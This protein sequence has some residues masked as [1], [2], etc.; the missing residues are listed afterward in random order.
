MSYG[1]LRKVLSKEYNFHCTILLESP[2][3]ETS[4]SGK[5]LQFVLLALTPEQ[6]LI[7][8]ETAP[9]VSKLNERD[10]N[11]NNINLQYLYP[12]ELVHIKVFKRSHRQTLKVCIESGKTRYFELAAMKKR[13]IF[14]KL[15]CNHISGLPISSKIQANVKGKSTKDHQTDCIIIEGKKKKNFRWRDKYLYL[16]S[17]RE[18]EDKVRPI[19][20]PGL[21]P[22]ED[23]KLLYLKPKYFGSW[24]QSEHW[25][26]CGSSGSTIFDF[27]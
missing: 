4:R 15:W 24:D 22:T 20:V 9:M 13:K 10:A 8:I 2:F 12:L 17:K 16:G 11:N 19:P 7:A 6:V 21:G 27:F 5:Y 3:I 18:T 1:K 23:I 25:V 26:Q 14:W